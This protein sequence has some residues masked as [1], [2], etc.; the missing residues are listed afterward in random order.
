MGQRLLQPAAPRRCASRCHQPGKRE[1]HPSAECCSHLSKKY[2]CV[3]NAISVAVH[4][5]VCQTPPLCLEQPHA[6]SAPAVPAIAASRDSTSA[7]FRLPVFCANYR[8]LSPLLRENKKMHSA[9]WR[10]SCTFL[11]T[12]IDSFSSAPHAI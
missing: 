6:S 8:Q 2:P 10:V 7:Y 9:Q 4:T 12:G 11:L 3:S 1:I 5:R